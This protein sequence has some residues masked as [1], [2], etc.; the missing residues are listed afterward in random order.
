MNT[1]EVTRLGC[2]GSERGAE[3]KGYCCIVT[4]SFTPN[5]FREDL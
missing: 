4:T 2:R 1:E 5:F 3:R